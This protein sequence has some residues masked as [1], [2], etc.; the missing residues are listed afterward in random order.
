[1]TSTD[2]GQGKMSIQETYKGFQMTSEGLGEEMIIVTPEGLEIEWTEEDIIPI[3]FQ[4]AKIF[5]DAFISGH[6]EY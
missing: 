5:V 4:D 2:R 6:I 1:M 3:T